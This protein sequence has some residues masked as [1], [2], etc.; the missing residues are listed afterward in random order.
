MPPEAPAPFPDQRDRAARAV[1][2]PALA[3]SLDQSLRDYWQKPDQVLNALGDL[4]GLEVADIGCGEGYFTLRLLDRV[5]PNGHVYATDIQQDVLNT[6]ATQIDK[7]LKDR[8][9][10]SLADE[11]SIGIPK[12]VDLIFLVQVF[13]EIDD[14]SDFIAKLSQIMAPHTRLVMIDSKHITDGNNG[15]TRPL[16]Q[17]QLLDRLQALGLEPDPDYPIEA[18][19]FLPKQFFYVLRRQG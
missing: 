4:E 11:H 10:L 12:P 16:N 1:Y 9:T 13:G 18:Y 2:N 14:P 3:A 6:L 19:D 5:G 17:N 7:D 8:I 15:Y